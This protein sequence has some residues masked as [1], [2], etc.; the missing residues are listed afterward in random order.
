MFTSIQFGFTQKKVE[1]GVLPSFNHKAS[2]NKYYDLNMSFEARYFIYQKTEG[3]KADVSIDY[4]LNDFTSLLARQITLN[5]TLVGGFLIRLRSNTANFRFIQQYIIESKWN[6][7]L[8]SHR[9]ATDQTFSPNEATELRA[10]YRLST[11]LPLNGIEADPKE[12]YIKLRGE[13]L[14]ILE[15]SQ[16]DLELRFSPYLGYT[17]PN[18]NKLELGFDNRIDSFI[19]ADLEFTSWTQINWYF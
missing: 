12:F 13:I 5:S 9:I 6:Q 11:E 10:R 15:G 7:I 4:S 3:E 16:Y 18:K 17:F 2:I 19:P 14:H 8:V 1:L